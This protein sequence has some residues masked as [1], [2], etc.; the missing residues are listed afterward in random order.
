M[1]N[2]ERL[3]LAKWIMEYTIKKGASQAAVSISNQRDIEIEMREQ[4][5]EKLKESTQNSLNL[6]VYADNRYS[7]HS[8]SDLTKERL[9][10][11]IE[12]AVVATRYLNEDKFRVL[13]DTKF[14]PTDLSKDLEINDPGYSKLESADRI[15]LATK[16]E[17]IALGKSD[18][19][20]S[21][22]AGCGDTY[23]ESV[24][25]HSNGF[26]GKRKGTVFYADASVTVK[27][28]DRGR[29]ADYYTGVSRF[30]NDLPDA[31]TISENA[32]QR[33]LQKIGQKKIESGKYTILVENRVMNRL[34]GV[35]QGPLSA[36]A[37]QQKSSYLEGKIG[38]KIASDKLTIIDNPFLKKGMG[39]RLYDGEGLAT[40]KRVI[41]DKG[42]LKE[43]FVDSYYG[44]KLG[45]EPNSGSTTN[46]VFEYGKHSFEDMIKSINRGIVITGFIGG[47][48]NGTTGDFSFGIVGQLVENGKIV[49]AINE[50]N[51]SENSK[52]FWNKLVETGNDPYPYSSWRRPSM[53]FEDIQLSGI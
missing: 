25:V 13:P 12:E 32:V 38:Q 10:P 43:Y 15:K 30:Y 1:T 47:N 20:I 31:K 49:Q 46:L 11:F 26:E 6:S 52:D 8:T 42:V 35:L 7:S 33:A 45:M 9:K 27:D 18:K 39:S 14:Y 17:K 51:V 28:G 40:K 37:L 34:L 50:M 21:A 29:P 53:L 36:R 19:I 41:I 44:R 4:K 2:N 16:I 3:D 48:S 5:L 22:S 23:F 24:L